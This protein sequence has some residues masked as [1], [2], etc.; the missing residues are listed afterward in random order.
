MSAR[1][2][3]SQ[4]NITTTGQYSGTLSTFCPFAAGTT[5]RNQWFEHFL[6][7]LFKSQSG[8]NIKMTRNVSG[9][10]YILI[11]PGLISALTVTLS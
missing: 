3:I 1:V 11:D 10:D 2:T 6:A 8:T 9:T 4:V 7:E 5:D